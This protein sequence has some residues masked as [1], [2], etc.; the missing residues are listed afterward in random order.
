MTVPVKSVSGQNAACLPYTLSERRRI[1]E[2]PKNVVGDSR[3]VVL[4][5]VVREASGPGN[6]ARGEHRSTARNLVEHHVGAYQLALRAADGRGVDEDL[7][8]D[9]KIG[10]GVA[11]RGGQDQRIGRRSEQPIRPV[12]LEP[13]R[14]ATDESEVADPLV[15]PNPF[16]DP[17]RRSVAGPPRLSDLPSDDALRA[18]LLFEKNFD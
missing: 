15:V 16:E 2:S 3:N 7:V 4:V 6:R 9:D 12:E 13:G 18:Y 5:V 8:A 14:A 11:L 17:A 1:H 10:V